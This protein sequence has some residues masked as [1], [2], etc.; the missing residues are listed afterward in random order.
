MMLTDSSSVPLPSEKEAEPLPVELYLKSIS[1][2]GQV[3]IIFN[4]DLL[5]PFNVTEVELS[6]LDVSRDVFRFDFKVNGDG[7]PIEFEI[8]IQEWTEREMLFDIIFREPLVVS[9]G[10]EADHIILKVRQPSHFTAKYSYLQVEQGFTVEREIPT[11]LPLDVSE[12]DVESAAASSSSSLMG[13]MVILLVLQ[14]AL[15]SLVDKLWLM[16][17]TL[18][19]A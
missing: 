7:D 10:E 9:S 5:V 16:V 8:I 11:Q 2:K 12:E 19:V 4:Q 13:L 15:K 17:L 14:I 3:R 1:R 6:G 18:Q